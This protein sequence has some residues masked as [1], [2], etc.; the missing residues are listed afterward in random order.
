MKDIILKTAAEKIQRYGLRKFTMDEIAEELKI[1]K[2]TLYK[3]F[4]GKDAIIHEYFMEIIESD[5]NN[6]LE[7]LEKGEALVD[8][9]NAII[10][11]YHKYRLPVSVYDEAY[12]FYHKEWE[13]VQKLKDFKLK[14]IN[15]VLKAAMDEGHI[16]K[17]INLNIIG[18]MLENTINTLLSY[19]F[20]SKND[21]TMKEAINEVLKVI[22][23][24]IINN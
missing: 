12:K 24:G 3:Y 19:E 22:L 4:S 2:K 20:L 6:T 15:D 17:D 9:I 1:S 10:Y 5:M 8:K 18:L 14:L 13:E 7:A 11:S 21:L 16:K 23:H